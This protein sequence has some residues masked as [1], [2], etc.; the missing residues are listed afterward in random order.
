MGYIPCYAKECRPVIHR[1]FERLHSDVY[2]LLRA[3]GIRA[4]HTQFFYTAYAIALVADQPLR[5]VL[6]TP[7]VGIP[8]A[9]LYDVSITDVRD[10]IH[11]TAEEISCAGTLLLA[12]IF[13]RRTNP[14][15]VQFVLGLAAYI[16][17]E[18][19]A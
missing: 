4:D 1:D 18:Y 16:N 17:K 15:A 11:C 13:S 6:F 7:L 8:V 14:S 9:R 5:S 10:A 12:D 2:A 3:L 19:H